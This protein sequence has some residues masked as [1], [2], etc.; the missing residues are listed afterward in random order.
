MSGAARRKRVLVVDDHVDSA[1]LVVEVATHDGHQAL[2]VQSAAEAI[3]V[4]AEFQPTL[5]VLD[6][7]LPGVDGY[8]VARQLHDLAAARILVVSGTVP[9]PEKCEA[10]GIDAHLLKPVDLEEL[11]EAIAH[12]DDPV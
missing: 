1:E 5:V 7:T 4:A 11:K 3:R 6:I 2:H 10:A 12:G 8:A 9:R